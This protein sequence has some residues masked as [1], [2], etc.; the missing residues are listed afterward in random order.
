MTMRA[1]V[2]GGGEIADLAARLRPL[3]VCHAD[4]A[5]VWLFGSVAKGTAR[6]DSDLDLGL[7]FMRRNATAHDHASL[8]QRLAYEVGKLTDRDHVDLV[9]LEPQGCVFCHH[10][11]I[12]GVLIYEGDRDRRIDFE[13]ET[14]VRAFDFRPT[15]T[16]ATRDKAQALRRW[17]R[18]R[19]DVR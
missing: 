9:V 11:L 2:S 13:S 6:P 17:L 8:I 4:I 16:L 5:A 3:F 15:W 19:H 7:V 14:M 1:T 10:V 12:D 18:D